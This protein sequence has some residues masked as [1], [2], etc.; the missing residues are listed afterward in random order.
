MSA[1]AALQELVEECARRLDTSLVVQDARRRIVA[2]AVGN[3]EAVDDVRRA[4][5][6]GRTTPPEIEAWISSQGV[7]RSRGPVRVRVPDD[8]SPG[9]LGRLGIPL[10]VGE[11]LVGVA[12]MI[13]ESDAIGETELALV[14][15]ELT[16][17]ALWLYEEEMAQRL[18]SELLAQLLSPDTEL[19]DRAAL[20]MLERGHHHDE[21]LVV[22]VERRVGADNQSLG[23]FPAWMGPSR[24]GSMRTSALMLSDHNAYLVPLS[25]H[26]GLHELLERLGTEAAG[27]KADS[28]FGVGQ[29]V[30]Q[31][32][33]V[34][35]SY[36]QALRAMR[37][38]ERL[39]ELHGVANWSE[40]GV[41]K[42]LPLSP[43][44]VGG[45][46]VLDQRLKPLLDPRQATLLETISAYLDHGG[47]VKATAAALNVHRGTLYYRLERVEELTGYT[48]SKGLDRLSLHASLLLA[49]LWGLA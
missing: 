6:L 43:H 30:S 34:E 3:P 2:Y 42:M 36:R 23:G 17:S 38:A 5:I 44:G 18:A 32:S 4:S 47:D 33:Q 27:T 15:P 41:F 8:I 24:A 49:R 9:Y 46:E 28:S 20:E 25:S 12:W 16:Q 45:E 37:C 48:L 21:Q 11:S 29:P 35:H 39:P 14:Q 40:L 19:R 26:L 7:Y 13:D 22:V 10:R 31:L 1:L